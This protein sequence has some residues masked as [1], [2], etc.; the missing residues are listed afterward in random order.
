[1]SNYYLKSFLTLIPK[2]LLKEYFQEKPLLNFSWEKEFT[3]DELHDVILAKTDVKMVE[4]DFRTINQWANE[5]GIM[6]LVEEA[7]SPI[8]KGG[9]EIGE[10]LGKMENEH[11]Q[12]MYVW[13]KYNSVFLWA[14]ELANWENRKGKIHYYVGTGLPCDGTDDQM[15]EKLGK[16]I[17]DYYKKQTKGSR[18]EVDYY[19]RTNPTRHF[20]FANPDFKKDKALSSDSLTDP[21][22]YTLFARLENKEYF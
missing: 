9:L 11:A 1:M 12:A 18:C 17:A 13:L 14:L 3:I 10:E 7:R 20:F 16:A 22:G 21:C 4:F 15:R 2:K 6:N 8:H 19:I 5:T